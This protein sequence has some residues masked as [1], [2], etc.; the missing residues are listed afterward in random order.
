M[1]PAAVLALA[2]LVAPALAQKADRPYPGT[3]TVD[4]VE[5]RLRP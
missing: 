4:L 1:T 3:S 2:I 5:F